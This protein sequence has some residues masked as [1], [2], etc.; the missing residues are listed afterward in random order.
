MK[1]K[2][3]FKTQELGLTYVILK[4]KRNLPRTLQKTRK[5]LTEFR[6]SSGELISVTTRNSHS[7]LE[8]ICRCLNITRD[9][10]TNF[11]SRFFFKLNIPRFW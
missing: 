9:F 3:K 6:F 10:K 8:H 5:Q 7:T 2:H 4:F 1:I 11:Q